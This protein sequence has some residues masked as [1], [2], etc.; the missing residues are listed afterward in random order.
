MPPLKLLKNGDVKAFLCYD[1][2]EL[3]DFKLY[4]WR[5][6]KKPHDVTLICIHCKMAAN[7]N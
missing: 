6:Y 2:G 1:C 4:Y 3:I 5:R 7:D